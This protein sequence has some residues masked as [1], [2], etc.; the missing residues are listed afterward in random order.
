MSP[1]K[2]ALPQP[3]PPPKITMKTK[4][5]SLRLIYLSQ[6]AEG[7]GKR[8]V[9]ERI[10]SQP[11][12]VADPYLTP[13]LLELTWTRRPERRGEAPCDASFLRPMELPKVMMNSRRP[14]GELW[15]RSFTDESIVPAPFILGTRA[16]FFTSYAFY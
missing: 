7:L 6:F 13:A 2:T 5:H 14:Q 10:K 11:H 1:A 8:R 16:S 4:L 15:T 3:V 9:D 12:S